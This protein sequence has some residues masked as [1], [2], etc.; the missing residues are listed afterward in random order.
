MVNLSPK[1]YIRPLSKEKAQPGELD[2]QSLQHLSGLVSQRWLQMASS[3]T[4]HLGNTG[5]KKTSAC[6]PFL[7][8]CAL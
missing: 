3:D 2:L 8:S 1:K 4:I 7:G 6:L 5:E